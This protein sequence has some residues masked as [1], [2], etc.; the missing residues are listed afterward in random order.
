MK[1][2]AL[3]IIVLLSTNLCQAQ[4]FKEWFRQ[5]KTQKQYLIDQI[6]HLKLYLELTEKG[7]KIAK[8][9]LTMISDIKQGEFKLH[10]NHFDSLRIVKSKVAG[11][12]KVNQIQVCY[13]RVKARSARLSKL[14]AG[15]FLTS[16]E[17][18]YLQRVFEGLTNDC[19]QVIALTN[20]V[21]E[22]GHLAMTDDER[23]S[24]IDMLYEQML[25]NHNFAMAFSN[26][27]ASLVAARLKQKVDVQTS[28]AAAGIN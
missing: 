6:A 16:S 15:G 27:A 7:Y 3:L 9:G 26:E 12:A 21:I 1:K 25:S 22:D 4:K 5:K 28:R 18:A 8:E 13:Q 10:K 19:D 23:L 17:T 24:R 20:E 2:T 11:Y 14:S